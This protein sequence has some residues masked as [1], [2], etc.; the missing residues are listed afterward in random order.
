MCG[1]R[2]PDFQIR[3]VSLSLL[4]SKR[5]NLVPL[6]LS[7]FVF[8]SHSQFVSVLDQFT[9]FSWSYFGYFILSM[10][11]FLLHSVVCGSAKFVGRLGWTEKKLGAS[12]STQS[13]SLHNNQISRI[14]NFGL[15]ILD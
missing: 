9:A 6:D 11:I 13:E 2:L 7:L 3:N 1:W 10:R 8:P 4:R 5:C 15:D 12:P 14:S